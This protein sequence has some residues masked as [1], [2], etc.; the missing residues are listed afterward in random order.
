MPGGG[1]ATAARPIV[2]PARLK[3]IDVP[4]YG[5]L[6]LPD[7]AEEEGPPDG[8]TLDQA[9][10]RALRENLGLAARRWQIPA[11]RAD[12]LTAG[13][14]SNPIFYAD[15]QLVPYGRYDKARPGGPTQYDVNISHPVD[16]SGKRLAR[17]AS[18]EVMV[19]MEEALYQNAAR[20]TVD[21]VDTAFVDVLA[22]RETTRYAHASVVG[23]TRLLEIYETLYR[24]SDVTRPEV[25]RVRA[26]LDAARL[27]VLDGEARL[28]NTR[29]TLGT[30]LN[31]PPERA[32]TLQIRGRLADLAP[33]PPPVS[34]LSR[35]ALETRPDLVAQRLGVRSAET[36]FDVA[37]ASRF[38]DAYVL[39]QPYTFQ[40]LAYLGKKSATSYA[41]GLTVPVPLFNRNQGGVAQA[42]LNVGQTETE[43]AA[44]ERRVLAEVAEA[45]R[46]YQITRDLVRALERDLLPA[47]RHYRDDTLRLFVAG[48]HGITAVENS[49]A[50][51]DY[52]HAVRL[53]RDA[54]IRHRRSMLSLNTA[55]GRNV[56]P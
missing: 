13:L 35:I 40:D 31:L 56:L 20:I 39:Y 3:I 30:L 12:V 28:Q 44:L 47:A 37:L 11:A 45:D 53:Y 29:R 5:P 50:Q 42:R 22:A 14:R 17:Q 21:N 16:Y 55:V 51:K 9:V 34:E 43:V 6:E 18:A 32:D 24:K 10:G 36:Q 23:L 7:A 52:N 19:C 38:G 8:L 26:T 25:E 15:S 27:A 2:A 54:L 33:P 48:D 4:L 49:A 1:A 41:L 46:Q